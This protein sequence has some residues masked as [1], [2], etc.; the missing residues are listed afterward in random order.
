LSRPPFQRPNLGIATRNERPIDQH[1]PPAAAA[2]LPSP[3]A[4]ITAQNFRPPD[5]RCPPGTRLLTERERCAMLRD[6]EDKREALTARL[7]NFPLRIDR[8][9]LLQERLAVQAERDVIE[10]SIQRLNR[11]YIFVGPPDDD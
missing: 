1:E 9:D 10:R 7:W 3:D 11:R 8:P 5:S 2:A 4:A 6:L